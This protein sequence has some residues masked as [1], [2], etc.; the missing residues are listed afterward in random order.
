MSN[1]EIY[2]QNNS[3]DSWSPLSFSYIS[4]ELDNINSNISGLNPTATATRFTSNGDFTTGSAVLYG[5]QASVTGNA[6]MNKIIVIKNG[7]QGI[8]KFAVPTS[9]AANFD[10]SPSVGIHFDEKITLYTTV[11]SNQ[12][13]S[14]CAIYKE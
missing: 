4:S 5:V 14:V 11:S 9:G 3:P 10:F 13:L 8:I 6:S 2:L 7:T 12:G 1:S